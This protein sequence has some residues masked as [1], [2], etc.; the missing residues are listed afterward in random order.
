MVRAAVK[1]AASRNL[2]MYDV[3]IVPKHQGKNSLIEHEV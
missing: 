3:N 1:M 2:K